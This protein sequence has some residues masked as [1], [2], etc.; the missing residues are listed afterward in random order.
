MLVEK[1]RPSA[2]FE[3]GL[4]DHLNALGVV[5]T[6]L[7]GATTSGCLRATAVDAHSYGFHTVIVEDAVFDRSRL[8]HEVS[9]FD[10][11]HKYADVVSL[12]RLANALK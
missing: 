4:A 11:H 5:S 1:G 7:A 8:N 3:T 6:V 9:L 2:F 10:L 12:G